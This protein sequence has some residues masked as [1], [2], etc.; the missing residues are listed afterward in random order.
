MNPNYQANPVAGLPNVVKNLLIINGLMFLLKV[1]QPMGLSARD[2]DDLLGL[3][4][5]GSPLFRPWQTI[6]YMFMHGDF[7]HLLFNMLG[8]FMLGPRLEYH[9]G[10]QRFLLYYMLC[11]IGAGLIYLGWLRV[12]HAQLLASVSADDVAAVKEHLLRVVQDNDARV[13]TDARL[14]ELM[15]LYY[16]PMVGASGAIFGVLLAFGMLY[17]NVQLFTFI[18]F[19]PIPMR[20]KWFVL[21]YGIAELY[22]GIQNNPMDNTAHFAH[23]G[24]MLVG[25]ILIKLWERQRP[26]Y[27]H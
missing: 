19:L 12:E 24:G 26:R 25:F 27:S 20:A 23:L 13:F 8:L 1:V 3:H 9:W 17:P 14:S 10:S 4:Y 7:T 11:G 22:A 18:G 6:S 2:L 5:P 21:F 15:S 16:T